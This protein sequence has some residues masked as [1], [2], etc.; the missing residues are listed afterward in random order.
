MIDAGAGAGGRRGRP[1]MTREEAQT[2]LERAETEVREEARRSEEAGGGGRDMAPAVGKPGAPAPWRRAV[3]GAGV[4]LHLDRWR[5]SAWSFL[6]K[7]DTDYAT[8]EA[9]PDEQIQEAARGARTGAPPSQVQGPVIK[10]PVWTWE[11]P[12]YFW[13]GG[14]A[15]GAS[16][17][18][19]A[20]DLVG[21]E[22][23]ARKARIVSLAALGPSPVLLI[24]D[25][26]RPERFY[27]MLRI[28][29]PRSP[30]SMGVWA[31]TAFGNF[32]AGSVGADLLGRRRTA[33]AMTVAQAASGVYLGS[34][35]GVLLAT[36]AVP[37]WARS[38]EFL[39]PIFV[40]TGTATG[41]ATVRLLLAATGLPPGHPTREA[42]ARIEAGAMTAELALS[43]VN[44][45]RL[46]RLAHALEEGTAG[47]LFQGAKALAAAGIVTR[48]A[49]RRLPAWVQHAASVGYLTAALM[50]RYAWVGAG[51]LSARD[52]EAVAR[53]ARAHAT[54][55]E[56]EAEIQ[57]IHAG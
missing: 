34:Y 12:L 17:V 16:F 21:D 24:M 40:A 30:M 14:M 39:G 57:V 36:T 9:P 29:K 2:A 45:K 46:G 5:D 27:K 22:E 51:K 41:A 42:L 13:L 32:A 54:R 10:P 18:A 47:R 35:T 28:I 7:A 43:W 4:A 55:A 48:L 52:D 49:H 1:E 23:S 56:P 6:F 20:C 19:M 50:F 26:G 33:R 38:R 15:S 3:E 37:V 8:A 53:T 11:V 31:L 44:E 25:L